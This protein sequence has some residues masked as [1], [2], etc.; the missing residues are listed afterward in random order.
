MKFTNQESGVNAV[1][2]FPNGEAVIS[3][4]NDGSVSVGTDSERVEGG[5]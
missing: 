2:F 1:K 4:G 3:G 5:I